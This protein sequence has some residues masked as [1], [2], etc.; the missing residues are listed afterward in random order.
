MT[1]KRKLLLT[2]AAF[3]MVTA[4]PLGANAA[5][6][7]AK[8]PLPEPVAESGWAYSGEFEAGWRTFIKRPPHSAFPW[9]GATPADPTG[10]GNRN[11]ISKFEEYG[12][13]PPGPYGEYL[14]ATLETKD[15]VWW[16]ELRAD[17]VG[18]NNQRYVYDAIK[19]G[20]HYFTF[21]WD[22]IPH[23]Y[24]TSAY[25]IWNG[26]GTNNLTT[27]VAIPAYATYSLAPLGCGPG[28]A[29]LS[30][31]GVGTAAQKNC[32]MNALLAGKGSIIDI[33]I[34]RERASAA[35]RWTPDPYWDVKASY[36]HEKR[37]GTQIAGTVFSG[38]GSG[39][40]QIYQMPRPI[41]DTTQ[42][43]KLN[44]EYFGSTPWGGRYSVNLGGG[45][46]LYD[47]SFTSYTVQNPFA[48]TTRAAA[49]GLVPGLQAP[50]AARISLA[51]SNQAYNG[52]VTT[53]VDLPM[54]TRWNST[55][56]YTS[57]QQNDPFIPYTIT[58]GI[59]LNAPGY[60]GI[61]ANTLA[62]LPAQ[63]LNGEVNT[64]LY[65]TNVTTRWNPQWR[66]TFRYRYYD[67]DNKTPELLFAPYVP[68]DSNGNNN[69]TAPGTGGVA[70]GGNAAAA[71]GSPAGTLNPTWR[72][73]L[74]MGY[75]KQNAS[76]DVQWRPANWATLGSSFGWEGWD[77]TRRETNHTNEF[78]GK[79]TAD[80]RIYDIG[81]LRSSVQYSERRHD[82]YDPTSL[83]QS[84][85]V[86]TNPILLTGGTTNY[87]IRKFD[88]ADRNQLKG[89]VIF[90]ISGPSGTV[91]RDFVLSPTFGLKNDD[92]REPQEN[93]G[94][95]T[96]HSWNA[97]IDGT[98]TFKPGNWIQAS[99]LY[100]TY[101][102]FQTGATATSTPIA[103]AVNPTAYSSNTHEKVHTIMA[104]TNIE[105][106][107]GKLDLK[108]GY[109][110]SFSTEDWD[111][112]TYLNYPSAITAGSLAF[113]TTRY[114]LQRLDA[115]L[116]HT[117][118]PEI[119]AKLGW[120][121]EVYLKAR[122]IW[123]R[124]S[125]DNWQQEM[126]TPFLYLGDSGLARAIEMGSTNPNYDAQFIQLSLNAKW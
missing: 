77:R 114:N 79:G 95:R 87:L 58:P 93:L 56:Q 68:E 99:Y 6:V 48:D 54:K 78:I 36:L 72:R 4:G 30:Y 19:S 59:T 100:E 110:I 17:N 60:T 73:A 5:D 49:A 67:N 26:V 115:S 7:P 38:P 74:A 107:P 50:A 116:K 112:N 101:D 18:N 23:L 105:L 12:K 52:I 118:D 98:Y 104:A 76:E 39:N 103:P 97:G 29:T 47:N 94:L 9:S 27:A 96:S 28:T 120:T 90:D 1:L 106:L 16:N 65:N 108:L 62:G 42:I 111:T 121:G 85:W 21:M 43:G 88:M 44:T 55:L 123:E 102:R 53:G 80:F 69:T 122:Y 10:K 126:M 57:M 124:S 11:N 35:Y 63:S 22:Q 61:A 37:E 40:M 3:T 113:P 75:T 25:N 34:M 117:V 92:Y 46:S 8:A 13:V 70:T 41:D 15:G 24:N 71:A 66:S 125:V 86:S 91:F 109:S 83:A 51:P 82:K 89:T 31:P 14:R 45:A 119:V 81:T 84:A 33:G 32:V 64:L 2:S 20:E